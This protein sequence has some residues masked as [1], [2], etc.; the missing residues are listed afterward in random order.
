MNN[1]SDVLLTKANDLSNSTKGQSQFP[2]SRVI[3]QA[4][5]KSKLSHLL[6]PFTRTSLS[7]IPASKTSETFAMLSERNMIPETNNS[8]SQDLMANLKARQVYEDQ[9]VLLLQSHDAEKRILLDELKNLKLA[10][11][12]LDLSA[13][14]ERPMKI[15]PPSHRSTSKNRIPIRDEDVPTH[16][17]LKRG[18]M[19]FMGFK[20][21][22]NAIPVKF[23]Q[24]L[25][26]DS[27]DQESEISNESLGVREKA[28]R[29][30]PLR[31]AVLIDDDDS[32]N[33]F[34]MHENLKFKNNANK[35]IKSNVK[36]DQMANIMVLRAKINDLEKKNTPTKRNFSM[37][38]GRMKNV[39]VKCVSA[40]D[41]KSDI[42]GWV[43]E[44]CQRAN[45]I[46]NDWSQKNLMKSHP[47]KLNYDSYDGFSRQN[48]YLED[49]VTRMNSGIGQPTGEIF[50]KG[51]VIEKQ[52]RRTH[53]KEREDLLGRLALNH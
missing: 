22:E 12:M 24:N 40:C 49:D 26:V 19:N 46:G 36:N 3:D 52:D 8:S 14:I 13:T 28:I 2:K 53:R 27:D 7:N 45:M 34:L 25:H 23:V 10:N 30:S 21:N 50:S 33:Q 39:Q 4:L 35:T 43:E 16:E 31:K 11:Q 51:D 38:S 6:P 29:T 5:T 15:S 42:I 47:E 37:E 1:E 17:K 18:F 20:T 48:N 9:K 41:S 32:H 44:Q